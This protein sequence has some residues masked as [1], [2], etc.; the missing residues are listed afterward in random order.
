MAED[1]KSNEPHVDEAKREGGT[2]DQ[3]TVVAHGHVWLKKIEDGEF[4]IVTG[5]QD[6]VKD[7]NDLSD[8]DDLLDNALI[9]EGDEVVIF[10]RRKVA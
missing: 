2:I 6:V 9:K 8:L 10:V 3:K 5:G 1:K 4:V 7:P